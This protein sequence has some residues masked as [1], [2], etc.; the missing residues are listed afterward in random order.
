MQAKSMLTRVPC[1]SVEKR[2]LS[3]TKQFGSTIDCNYCN[4][5]PSLLPSVSSCPNAKASFPPATIATQSPHSFPPSLPV[6]MRRPVSR[7]QLL[8]TVASLTVR[9]GCEALDPRVHRNIFGH[10]RICS[11]THDYTPQLA[12]HTRITVVHFT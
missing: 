9:P 11:H 10:V 12:L 2:Y 7:L 8:H 3:G 5:I 4:T 1:T 6:P